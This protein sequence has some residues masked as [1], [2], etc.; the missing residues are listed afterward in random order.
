MKKNDCWQPPT[1]LTLATDE[2]HLWLASLEQPPACVDA[3]LATLAP[4]EQKR[5]AR[6]VFAKDRRSFTVARGILR[7]LLGRYL[8]TP[9]ASLSFTYNSYGKPAL[10]E[11]A[12]Q[13]ALCFNLSHSHQMALF[14]FAY[15]CEL[16]VDI[17][18]MRDLERDDY[19]LMADSHFSP[20]EYA[21]LSALP[22]S[23]R[24]AAFFRCWSRKEAYIK[25]RGMGI[26][27]PLDSFDV[28]CA[29]GE[30]AA[31]LA[32]REAPHTVT[33]WELSTPTVPSDYA[34]ALIV[35]RPPRRIRA[36]QWSALNI[37]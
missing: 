7:A 26:S 25:A 14:A 15:E 22:E 10:L 6:F 12:V 31:L 29:P 18:Y 35:T 8:Q 24:K 28:S 21:T 3:F 17:E 23:Q 37:V 9:P 13:P 30:P 32:S 34:A 36:Y 1:D 27:I 4:D 33:S 19:L 16:G 5:A 2:V 11:P 20:G